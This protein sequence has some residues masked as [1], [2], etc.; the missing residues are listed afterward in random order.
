MNQAAVRVRAAGAYDNDRQ[1]LLGVVCRKIDQQENAVWRA[2]LRFMWLRHC[3]LPAGCRLQPHHVS[4]CRFSLH[5]YRRDN[6]SR[7]MFAF[8]NVD[9]TV[10][11]NI[12]YIGLTAAATTTVSGRWNVWVKFARI[13]SVIFSCRKWL[14]VISATS[15]C[16]GRK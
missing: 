8:P 15:I 7:Y 16:F 14:G 5:S 10:L 11:L 9:N 2:R 13:T 4:L 12:V 1:S 6:E 3:L